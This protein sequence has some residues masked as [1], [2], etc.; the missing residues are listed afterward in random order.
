VKRI[1]F[2]VGA[3]K[4]QQ[5]FGGARLSIGVLSYQGAVSEHMD[6]LRSIGIDAVAV[7]TAESL[8][9]VNGLILPGG[10]STCQGKLLCRFGLDKHIIS[11]V[12]AGMPIFGTCTGAILLARDIEGSSQPRLGV[13]DIKVARNA[14]GAQV[15]S[16]ETELDILGITDDEKYGRGPFKTFFIRAPLITGTDSGVEIMALLDNKVV[17]AKQRSMLACSFHPE[18]GEDTRI[19]RYF[20]NMVDAYTRRCKELG[21]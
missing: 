12:R 1:K 5:S 7:K 14:F 20:A 18:L 11:R 16:F 3:G 6:M 19:H 10:E 21:K 4:R 15:D 17:L 2:K 8:D 13:M 9:K